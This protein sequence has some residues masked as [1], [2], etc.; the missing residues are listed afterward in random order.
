MGG[1]QLGELII[2]KED[3]HLPQEQ[4]AITFVGGDHRHSI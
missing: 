4:L 3:V 1:P 2:I